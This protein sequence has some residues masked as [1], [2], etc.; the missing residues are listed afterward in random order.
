[1]AQDPAKE[2]DMV[3]YSEH[4]MAPF[5]QEFPN[6]HKLM[7][8]NMVGTLKLLKQEHILKTKNFTRTTAA[9]HKGDDGARTWGE[10][11]Q[12]ITKNLKNIEGLSDWR[13]EKAREQI[14]Q[15][16]HEQYFKKFPYWPQPGNTQSGY[17]YITCSGT[18]SAE[19]GDQRF[20]VTWSCEGGVTVTD[21]TIRSG[22]FW[23]LLF[24]GGEINYYCDMTG[25]PTFKILYFD[26]M[27][28]KAIE[29]LFGEGM[30]AWK[31]KV[32]ELNDKQAEADKLREKMKKLL[33]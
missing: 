11:K 3:I 20:Q 4:I 5:K 8:Y 18:H 10:Y 27:Q 33:L 21:K 31:K 16:V 19:K 9:D 6:A 29:G 15:V 28:L 13:M 17:V 1:M 12:V 23:E 2:L 26:L 22:G 7:Q 25:A 24:G 30:T 14:A 32:D